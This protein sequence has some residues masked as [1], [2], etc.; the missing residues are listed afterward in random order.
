MTQQQQPRVTVRFV[1][2]LVGALALLVLGSMQVADVYW[3]RHR[4]EVVTA[5]VVDVQHSRRTDT[6]KVNYLTRDGQPVTAKTSHY[7]SA[8]V[9]K[10][11][12]VRY[13]REKPHRMQAANYSLAYTFPVLVYGGFAVFVVLFSLVDLRY[14]VINRLRGIAVR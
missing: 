7:Y 12:E 10:T 2:A 1:V 4:G 5:T 3:L 8:E 13:D 11:I 14:N 6:M 9:G